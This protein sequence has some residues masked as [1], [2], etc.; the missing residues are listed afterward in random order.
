[1]NIS[2][3]SCQDRYCGLGQYTENLAIASNSQGASVKAYRKDHS[4]GHLFKAYPYRSF[5]KLRPY[6]A[7][8]YLSKAIASDHADIWQ[9]D[10]VDAAMA[11]IM[12]GKRDNLFVTI[13]DAIPFVHGNNSAAFRYYQWQLERANRH[14]Q[15]II[16]VSNHAKKEV[17]K[18]TTINPDRIH[19]VH[20]GINHQV[21]QPVTHSNSS[22]TN[23]N[24]SEEFV[25][26]YLGGLGAPH[27]N[28][29]ALLH[30]AKLL[31]QARQDV[32]FEIGGHLPENHRLRI[33]A[34][35]M[36]LDNLVF[37][38]FIKDDE[39][40]SFYQGADLFFFPS[41]LEGFGF[42]PLEAM[43]CGTPALVSDIPVLRETLGTAACFAH[44]TPEDFADAILSMK[45]NTLLRSELALAGI[46][47]AQKYTWDKAAKQ[48]K[49][50]YL[51]AVD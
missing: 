38:G 42:P 13:H 37:K 10:Y 39:M 40:T 43:A 48:M 6:V 22:S 11:A 23:D 50:L 27:K 15:A 9:A 29:M 25:V 28:A 5:K 19:V 17:I 7:P 33:A 31:Q 36:Q 34:K 45:R 16:V 8:Y 1:M 49:E 18:H 2:Y 35:E 30:T 47:Q 41:L 44:P 20:N 51:S 12:A 14:A 24:E 4:D 3:L 46:K 26:R 32:R 21:Y